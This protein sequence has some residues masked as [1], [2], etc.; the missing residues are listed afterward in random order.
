[1]WTGVMCGVLA[2]ALWGTVFIVPARLSAFSP[3]ELA[4]GRYLV[5]GLISL[6]LMLPAPWRLLRR[7]TRADWLVLLRQATIANV[8]YYLLLSYGV[9]SAGVAPT[10]LIIGLL[11]VSVPLLGHRD[12]G[13]VALRRLAAP[14]LLIAAGIACINAD[15]FMHTSESGHGAAATLAGMLAAAGSLLCW[16]WYALDNAR[17][18]KADGRFGAGEW[19][20]LFGLCSGLLALPLGAIAMALDAPHAAAPR[21]WT[22]FWLLNAGIALGASTIGNR[23]WNV[24]TRRVPVTLSGQLILFETLFALLYGFIDAQ[25]LPRMLEL[26]AVL[27]LVGGVAW[28]ARLH[29]ESV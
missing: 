17:F 13:A 20:A 6:L 25:R 3:L 10:S 18:L 14:L 29:A 2:G 11:P 15:A 19:S 16:S 12:D 7:L 4:A 27:L 21:D 9:K 8:V 1:M 23:L 26:C 24:A 28:S 22:L 5:Y